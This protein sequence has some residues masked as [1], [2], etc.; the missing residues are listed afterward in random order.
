VSGLLL[1]WKPH[2]TDRI[3]PGL[4]G[5]AA[6]TMLGSAFLHI[7]P[8]SFEFLSPT[9]ALA[10]S[11]ASFTF[12]FLMEKVFHWHHCHETDCEDAQHHHSMGYINLVGDGFH[13]FLDGMIIAAAFMVSPWLGFSTSFV[14]ALHELPQELGDFGVL[15]SSG[16]S[17]NQALLS[18]FVI[19][20]AAIFGG[21]F[22]YFFQFQTV[23]LT[24]YLLPVAAG[25]FIYLAASDLVPVMKDDKHVARSFLVFSLYL[26]GIASIILSGFF[27]P[28]H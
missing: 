21:C 2:L 15:L 23:A 13:N 10:I 9:A 24:Q 19:G 3:L 14:I 20:C 5:L 16:F 1:A 6:G 28:E 11:L 27:F 25:N 22:A 18:N 7:L 17:R 4:V 12:F 26:I 8:E